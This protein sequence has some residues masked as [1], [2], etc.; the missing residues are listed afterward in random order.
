MLIEEEDDNAL[1]YF[2]Y[3]KEEK[4]TLDERDI[5]KHHRNLVSKSLKIGSRAKDSLFGHIP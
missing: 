3:H 1:E 2:G 4:Y 5:E